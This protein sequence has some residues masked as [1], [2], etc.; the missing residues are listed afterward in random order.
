MINQDARPSRYASSSRIDWIFL[1]PCAA[2]QTQ[3]DTGIF[4]GIEYFQNAILRTVF[5][6]FS[7]LAVA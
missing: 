2:V 4:A 1:R 7:H 3:M 5:A 6:S